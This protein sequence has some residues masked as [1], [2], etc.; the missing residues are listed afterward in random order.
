MDAVGED[1]ARLQIQGTLGGKDTRP[2]LG[3]E[4]Q[5]V[6]DREKVIEQNEGFFF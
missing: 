5:G 2:R 4:W 1:K 6:R 3:C